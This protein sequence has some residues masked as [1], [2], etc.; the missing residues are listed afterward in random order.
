MHRSGDCPTRAQ[1]R[2]LKVAKLLPKLSG[3]GV[4][5][6]EKGGFV[7]RVVGGVERFVLPMDADL[8]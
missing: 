7:R 1:Y 5:V 8:M 3:D 2:R 4:R 6:L